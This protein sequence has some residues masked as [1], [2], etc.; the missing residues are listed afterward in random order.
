MA[1]AKYTEWLTEDGLL[2]IEMWA[3]Q[4]FSDEQIAKNMGIARASLYSWFNQHSDIL[5]A[6]KRGRKP[7]QIKVEDAL[8]SR[9]DWRTVEEER[10][11]TVYNADQEVVSRKV[12]NQKKVI[13][14]DTTALI[15]A[16][17]NLAPERFSDKPQKVD[18]NES[19]AFEALLNGPLAAPEKKVVNLD[20]FKK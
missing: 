7:V 4:G 5:D 19:D 17:K 3:R 18:T 6:V 10:T 16:L 9:C 8:Y 12:I 2:T 13:P 14:P 1:K 11:E 20:N 15:F